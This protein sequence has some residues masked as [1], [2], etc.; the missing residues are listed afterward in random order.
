MLTETDLP[1]IRH[2]ITKRL[3]AERGVR[4]VGIPMQAKDGHI[5]VGVLAVLDEGSLIVSSQFHLPIPFELAHL[6]N[7]IDEMAEQYK[8]AR[9]KFWASG[10]VMKIPATAL[11]GSGLR[12]NWARYG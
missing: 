12:G 4:I 5:A 7:E 10:R 11:A 6:H 3:G 8:A 2:A 9:V 1:I